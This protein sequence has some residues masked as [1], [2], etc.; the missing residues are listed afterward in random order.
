[1][2]KKIVLMHVST[3]SQSEGLHYI[4]LIRMPQFYLEISERFDNAS[5]VKVNVLRP[6]IVVLLIISG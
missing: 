5:L 6:E 2:E 4:A 1:M 3:F